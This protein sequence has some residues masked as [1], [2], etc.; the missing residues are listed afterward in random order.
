MIFAISKPTNLLKKNVIHIIN[1][2]PMIKTQ[3]VGLKN[4][5]G[6]NN[7][8]KI[9][10]RH[11]GAGHKRKY[12]KINFLRVINS[13]SVIIGI[14]YDPYRNLNIAASYDYKKKIFFYILAPKKIRIG[15]I[16]ESGLSPEFYTG[17]ALPVFKIPEG[18]FIHNITSN[19][20]KKAQYS[21]AA[22]AFAILKE[23]NNEYAKIKLSSKKEKLISIQEYATLGILNEKYHSLKNIKKAGRSRWLNKRP[24]VRGV[25]M[26][27]I[28][29]PHG[30]G[31]GKKSGKR[32]SPWGKMN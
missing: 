4:S 20:K 24:S 30:G 32:V 13:T 21:R 7:S 17:N 26:N 27:P 10:V 31:E 19:N 8:G 29:H 15:D 1:K 23:K 3:I 6:R 9:T 28:D 14:E 16:I 5:T 2:P 25:A 12:R 22:G 11:K 18:S